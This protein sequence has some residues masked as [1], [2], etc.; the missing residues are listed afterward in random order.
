MLAAGC[1]WYL[2]PHLKG[3]RMKPVMVKTQSGKHAAKGSF[4]FKVYVLWFR[5]VV[6][7]KHL[8]STGHQQ[9]RPNHVTVGWGGVLVGTWG[10]GK[11]WGRWVEGGEGRGG[12]CVGGGGAICGH[13]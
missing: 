9:P 10:C 6:W 7:G 11:H 5:F 1:F 12:A 4:G 8:P 2:R 3:L 13:I